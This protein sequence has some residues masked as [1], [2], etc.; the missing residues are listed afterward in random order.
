MDQ[1]N[2]DNNLEQAHLESDQA[3]KRLEEIKQ[4]NSLM[5]SQMTANNF[6]V[7]KRKVSNSGN[8][9]TEIIKPRKKKNLPFTDSQQKEIEKTISNIQSEYRENEKEKKIVEKKLIK[10]EIKLSRL[11]SKT[12][13]KIGSL[14]DKENKEQL[15]KTVELQESYLNAFDKL[16]DDIDTLVLSENKISLEDRRKHIYNNAYNAETERARKLVQLR[17]SNKANWTNQLKENK[18]TVSKRNSD[19]WMERLGILDDDE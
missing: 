1:K 18:K 19:N 6:Y 13:K 9:Q 2:K 14:I 17:N 4:S 3:K 10:E 8:E 15:E 7:P 11:I 5:N 16:H 12:N